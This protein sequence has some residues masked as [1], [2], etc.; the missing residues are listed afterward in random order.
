MTNPGDGQSGWGGQ[1]GQGDWGQQDPANPQHHGQPHHGQPTYGQPAY[2]QPQYGQPGYGQP[3]QQPQYGQPGYG[4]P[5]QQAQ[6]GQPPYGQP[7]QQAQYGQ[8][9]YG[10]QQYGQQQQQYGGYGGLGVFSGGEGPPPKKG[11]AKIWI[12]VAV[13][14][15]LLGGGITAFLLVQGK[16]SETVAN[17]STPAPSTTTPKPTTTTTPKSG[18]GNATCKASKPDWNCLAVESLFSSYEVPK[19]WAP[20]PNSA[21]VDGMKD[22]KLT[23][24]TVYGNYDCGGSRYNRG[25]TGGVVVPPGDSTATAKDFAQ[26]LGTQYY[27]SGKSIDVKLSEPKAVKVPNGDKAEIEGVQVD[28]TITTTGSECLATKGMVKVLVLK[29]ST[30]SLVFM[31]N[32]DLEGGPAEPKPPTEADLQA[33]VDSVKPLAG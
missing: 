10:Q 25:S 27:S 23:G 29:G 30:G 18:T 20:S 17:T 7:D 31:A 1:P 13:V 14:V 2:G 4:P 5:D 11:N 12:A 32:G 9:P 8:P 16:D 19:A 33:V 22:V 26:K 6:Y 3:D 28:A 24:L 15:L 21:A